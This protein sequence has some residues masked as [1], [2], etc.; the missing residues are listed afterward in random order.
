MT[1][2]SLSWYRCM[3]IE[4]HLHKD[5]HQTLCHTKVQISQSTKGKFYRSNAN[6][7]SKQMSFFSISNRDH[8][9]P[10]SLGDSRGQYLLNVNIIEAF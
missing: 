6:I 8:I 7:S 2:G 10:A 3:K 4:M 9:V 1:K 5:V